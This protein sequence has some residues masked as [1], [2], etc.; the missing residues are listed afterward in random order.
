MLFFFLFIFIW[1]SQKNFTIFWYVAVY[2]AYFT[3]PIQSSIVANPLPPSFLDTYDLSTSSLG[4]NTLCIVIIT[5]III[6]IRCLRISLCLR[7]KVARHPSHLSKISTEWNSYF[8]YYCSS[9][10]MKALLIDGSIVN[11]YFL[12]F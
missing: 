9:T 10:V 12:S 1:V 8:C 2:K 4:C 5:I 11:S 3:K 7:L 6:I